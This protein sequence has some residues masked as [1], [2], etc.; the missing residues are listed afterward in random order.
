MS[1]PAPG[2]T[3]PPALA[4]LLEVKGITRDY[5]VRRRSLF[6]RPKPFR[7]V[8]DVSFTMAPAQ[9]MALVGRS[10]CGKSTLARIILALDEPSAGTI[11]FRGEMITGRDQ[12][13]LRPARRDMQVI[14]Q[15]PYGSFDPRQRVE[16]LVAEPLHLLDKRP[17]RRRTAR[18]GRGGAASGRAAARRH[19]EISARVFRRPA[20]APVDRP[21]HH[22]AAEADCRGRTGLGTR[23]VDPRP[24]SR[25]PGGPQPAPRRSPTCSSP[26]T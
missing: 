8:D 18:P 26:T 22:H 17:T 3:I 4:P 14:F 12:A 13:A 24:D 23:R 9:S 15:D 11:A 19:A 6:D 2:R 10:G 21:R 1:R 20:P 25:P 16:R 7:A 5:P